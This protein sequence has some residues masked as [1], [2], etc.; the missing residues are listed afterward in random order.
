LNIILPKVVI[1]ELKERASKAGTSIVEYLLD[2]LTRDV[3]P[4]VG[5]KSYIRGAEELIE[6]AREEFMKGDLRQASE[7]IWSACA[8]AIKAH[9]LARR[10]MKLESHRDLWMYKNEIA[11]EL[12]DWVRITFNWQILCIKTSTKT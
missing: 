4:S 2:I 10:G 9:A 8:L 3:D 7:K 11:K 6:Q 5:A 12:G 1:E